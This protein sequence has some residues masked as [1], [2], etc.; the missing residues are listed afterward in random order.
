MIVAFLVITAALL[1]G[2]AVAKSMY[3]SC[4][5]KQYQRQFTRLQ[6]EIA[7]A[8]KDHAPR[9]GLRKQLIQLRCKELRS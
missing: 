8:E 3:R 1:L 2:Y 4:F 7:Q 9:K 5:V 6:L